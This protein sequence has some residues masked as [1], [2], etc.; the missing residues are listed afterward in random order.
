MLASWG[1]GRRG[2]SLRGQGGPRGSQGAGEVGGGGWCG[3][4]GHGERVAKMKIISK[5]SK[6]AVTEARL[7]DRVAGLRVMCVECGA[8][9]EIEKGDEVKWFGTR[10]QEAYAQCPICYLNIYFPVRG[11]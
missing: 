11:L 9:V 1:Y 2:R 8:V 10:R 3:R 5:P 4:G 6:Q 7:S